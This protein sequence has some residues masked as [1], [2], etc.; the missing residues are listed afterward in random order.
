MDRMGATYRAAMRT[1]TE[2]AGIGGDLWST[3]R[4]RR[5]TGGVRMSRDDDY[6]TCPFLGSS[7]NL[8]RRARYCTGTTSVS[9]KD[10]G[11]L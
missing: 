8:C 9:P 7:C 11:D 1:P 6:A 2:P 10:T 3:R 4:M 5:S